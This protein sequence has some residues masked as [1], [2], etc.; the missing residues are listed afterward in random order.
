MIEGTQ[1]SAPLWDGD[2]QRSVRAGSWGFFVGVNRSP[3]EPLIERSPGIAAIGVHILE[4][5]RVVLARL[6]TL[7]RAYVSLAAK[8]SVGGLLRLRCKTGCIGT[9]CVCKCV[10]FGRSAINQIDCTTRSLMPGSAIEGHSFPG[11]HLRA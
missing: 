10:Q 6:T 2:I 8:D 7:A 3:A 9:A 1:R 5:R 11:V 4:K